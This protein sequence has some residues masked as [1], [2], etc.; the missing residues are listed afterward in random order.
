MDRA[1]DLTLG[2]HR[3]TRLR[4]AAVGALTEVFVALHDDRDPVVVKRLHRHLVHNPAAVAMLA[5][6]G[7][8]L[9]RFAFTGLA[10]LVAEGLD[11]D[12][13][14]LVQK[15]LEGIGLDAVGSA[16]PGG[17]GVAAAAA[18]GLGL[19]D[20][21]GYVHA[22][23]DGA[24]RGLEVVHRDLAPGN[25]LV[26]PG[27]RVS[28][29]DFGIATSR[30]RADPD[31][32][33]LKGSRGYMAPEVITGASTADA[34]S[35]LFV[36]GVLLFETATGQR[37]FPGDAF[38]SMTACVEGPR[39]EAPLPPA[40]ADV[41]ARTLDPDPARRFASAAEVA[42]ALRAAASLDGFDPSP[43]ALDAALQG[44]LGPRWPPTTST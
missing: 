24:G 1:M 39:P 38:A 37:C 28:L 5:H 6:E 42:A 23:T 26:A 32:G 17:L 15:R 18:L 10:P 3:M 25:V 44:P 2:P 22:V 31:R 11:E 4:P 12:R 19:L 20:V 36:L 34:R 9:G 29:V 30:W 13:L 40:F 16:A 21:L 43:A 8:L 14:V 35:D 41:I 7:R 27:G 33:V